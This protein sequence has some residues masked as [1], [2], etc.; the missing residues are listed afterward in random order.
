MPI[1]SADIEEELLTSNHWADGKTYSK[2][3]G[4]QNS[5]RRLEEGC[6]MRENAAAAEARLAGTPCFQG[7]EGAS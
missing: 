6:L 7:L 5:C 1:A 2:T 4:K 3:L